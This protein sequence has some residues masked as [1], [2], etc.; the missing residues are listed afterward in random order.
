VCGAQSLLS[1]DVRDADIV[2]VVRLLSTQSGQNMVADGS[3]K[4]QHVTLRLRD[5]SFDE[6]LRALSRACGLSVRRENGIITLGHAVTDA[7]HA[8]AVQDGAMAEAIALR[9]AKPA[10][11]EREL[12]NALPE[13]SYLTDDRINAVI[14]TGDQHL[15]AVARALLAA[16]DKAT[17]Q[18]MFEVRVADVVMANDQSNVGIIFGGA[19]IGGGPGQAVYSFANRSV[20][21]NATLNALIQENRAKILATPRL[22]TQNN[23][24]ANLLVGQ[25]YPIVT[26]TTVG[27]TSTQQVQYVD[28]GVKLRLTPVIGSDGSVTAELHPEYSAI[29]GITSL[30]YPIIDN[31]KVDATLRVKDNET[32]VLGGLLED[33][34][35]ETVTRV[36]FLSDIPVFGEVFKNR[37]KAHYKDEI[38]FLITPHI[39]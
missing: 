4:N 34:N 9:Y 33:V 38:V 26:Q 17:P 1:L 37:Q 19:G 30:G 13:G 21:I 29:E 31:R 16:I 32:I 5:V 3:V 24:E 15:Q 27:V 39:L 12:H 7:T 14:I 23:R 20:A 22:T 35:S 10:D 28:I 36:P 2:D 25:S 8:S 18:V 6:A 11:V